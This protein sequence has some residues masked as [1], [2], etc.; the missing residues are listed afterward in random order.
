MYGYVFLPSIM[1]RKNSLLI[2]SVI[3]MFVK[4][5]RL[6]HLVHKQNLFMPV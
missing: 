2:L 1:G 5:R 4:S 6:K 3:P